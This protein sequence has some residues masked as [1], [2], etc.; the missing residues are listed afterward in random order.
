M[1]RSSPHRN[2]TEHRWLN[3]HPST[4][5]GRCSASPRMYLRL[6]TPAAPRAPSCCS[7]KRSGCSR[8]C[9]TELIKSTLINIVSACEK[10]RCGKVVLHHPVI[11]LGKLTNVYMH[12]IFSK[13]LYLFWCSSL[14][15]TLHNNSHPMHANTGPVRTSTSTGR[16]AFG[17]YYT[18]RRSLRL[19]RA[20]PP[21][22]SRHGS[23]RG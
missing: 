11:L 12:H 10:R 13:Y 8:H 5:R 14:T 3:S 20:S 6:S 17:R 18:R 4:F 21:Y 23:R 1:R 16:T 7:P 15:C 2:R 22:S 9:Q 19:V